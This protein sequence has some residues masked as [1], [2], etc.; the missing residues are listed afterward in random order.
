MRFWFQRKTNVKVA[1]VGFRISKTVDTK[2]NYGGIPVLFLVAACLH[3]NS[4]HSPWALNLI[5]I[6]ANVQD[7]VVPS[8][9]FFLFFF[10]LL[11]SGQF[12][13]GAVLLMQ[14]NR[15]NEWLSW[16]LNILRKWVVEHGEESWDC[17]RCYLF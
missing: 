10:L 16:G 6:L 17:N 8:F 1:G 9:S 3:R 14:T 11:F 7:H 13:N 2:E 5:F 15:Y 12:Q 4:H